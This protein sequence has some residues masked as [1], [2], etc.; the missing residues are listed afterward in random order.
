MNAL[1]RSDPHDPYFLE[2]EGQVL[3]ESG[4]AADA[5]LPLREAVANRAGRR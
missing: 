5:I 3:L 1:L 2:L 4:P